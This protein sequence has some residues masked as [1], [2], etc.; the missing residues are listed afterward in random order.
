MSILTKN[1]KPKICRICKEQFVRTRAIQP[2][3]LKFECQIE[4]SSKM[5]ER[6]RKFKAKEERKTDK[7]KKETL[8]SRS[9]YVK[10]AQAVFN[11]W[12]R[13]RD[14]KEPC[15]SCNRF[16]TGQY[17]AGHYLS[18]GAHPE[19]RFEPLNVW[20]QCQPCN[21]HLSGNLL[22]YRK[23]LIEKI[24]IEKVEWLEG[25]HEVKKLNV[26]DLKIIIQKYKKKLKEN[27]VKQ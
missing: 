12:V 22:R 9:D 25:P 19:L 18:V 11:K 4:F 21:T 5:V 24:G 10:E 8:K 20:K 15:I 16:H 27:D 6:R 3:C 2:V 14:D 17:H 7:I 1:P 26:D 13:L 23:V